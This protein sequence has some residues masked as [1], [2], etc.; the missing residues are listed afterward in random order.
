M[1]F[2][3]EYDDSEAQV[4]TGLGAPRTECVFEASC[5]EIQV[6]ENDKGNER[7]RISWLVEKTLGS[8]G[9]PAPVKGQV[10]KTNF[11]GLHAN[12]EP[13]EKG[14]Y[15]AIFRSQNGRRTG[16]KIRVN[17]A[18]IRAKNVYI[19]YTPAVSEDAYPKVKFVTKTEAKDLAAMFAAQSNTDGMTPVDDSG[20]DEVPF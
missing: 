3:Y 11:P 19:H 15:S 4:N 5:G 7:V 12:S 2:D 17:E 16:K 6:Y 14:F 18:N 8:V 20:D 10:A 13:W 1:A 9:E